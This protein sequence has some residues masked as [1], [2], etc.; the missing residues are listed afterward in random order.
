M[1]QR[2]RFECTV[3]GSDMFQALLLP[4]LLR[5]SFLL[6]FRQFEARS[7]VLVNAKATDGR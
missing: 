2:D 6:P 1:G 3:P 5:R 4:S 7:T